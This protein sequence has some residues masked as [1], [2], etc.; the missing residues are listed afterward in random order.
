MR[1]NRLPGGWVVSTVT[2]LTMGLLAPAHGAENNPEADPAQGLRKVIAIK[3]AL[4]ADVRALNRIA[5]YQ[6][7]LRR[8]ARVDPEAARAGRR[9]RSACLDA[10]GNTAL[11]DA[12]S[13]TYG[14]VAK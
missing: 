14:G 13:T 4:S 6:Q 5:D 2:V 10:I 1:L 12:L 11:C 7:E 9:S 8:L 3:Q